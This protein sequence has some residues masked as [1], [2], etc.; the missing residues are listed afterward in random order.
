MNEWTK[1]MNERNSLT[2]IPDLESSSL[3]VLHVIDN[4]NPLPS[5]ES[6]SPTQVFIAIKAKNTNSRTNINPLFQQGS[7]DRENIRRERRVL[8]FS[9]YPASLR[10]K[11]G[12]SPLNSTL[13]SLPTPYLV[14]NA[15]FII[16]SLSNLFPKYTTRGF[17]WLNKLFLLFFTY[18]FNHTSHVI[19]LDP[20]HFSHSIS[21]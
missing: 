15:L 7:L 12:N 13:T 9:L 3:F 6:I 2:T 5:T 21:S 20:T 18:S 17:Y 11:T 10:L 19:Y 14:Q 8:Y 1:R 4:T 16:P